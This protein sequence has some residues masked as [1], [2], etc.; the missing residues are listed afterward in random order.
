MPL[1]ERY[2]E[3]IKSKLADVKNIA[4]IK[5]GGSITA[6]LFLQEFIEKTPWAHIGRALRVVIVL[7]CLSN[8]FFLS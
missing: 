4:G 8:R 2:R 1:E 7:F 3:S 5:G 6:A